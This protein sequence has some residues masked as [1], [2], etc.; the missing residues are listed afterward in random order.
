MVQDPKSKRNGRLEVSADENSNY[1]Y[2]T[3]EDEWP[4]LDKQRSNTPVGRQA[5]DARSIDRGIFKKRRADRDKKPTVK[6]NFPELARRL[7]EK[8]NP[9]QRM[10]ANAAK[11]RLMNSRRSR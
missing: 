9:A 5:A 3:R 1:G 2:P 6:N 10:V 4:N 11:K 8:D 7:S